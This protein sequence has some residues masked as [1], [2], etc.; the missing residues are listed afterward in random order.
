MSCRVPGADDLGSFWRLL[1]DGT[2][3]IGDVPE[4]RWDL[5]GIPDDL[6]AAGLRRG[7]FLERVADF[8]A[9]FFG[10]SPR[11][12]AAMDPRQRLALELS[13]TA[14]EHAGIVPERLRGE[15]AAVFLGA[16]G[17]DYAALTQLHGQDAVSHHSLTGLSR[18][19]IANRISYHLGLRG[20]SLTV[21]TAQSSS[22]VAVHLAGES[23]LSGATSLALAGGVHL[24]LTP[25]GTLAFAR[26]GALSPDGRCHVF[27]ARAAGT[28]RGEGAG[29]VVL[30]RL[31]DALA[32]GDRIHCVLLG[33]AVNND[34]GGATFT[35]PDG[36]AQR[37]LLR[38]ACDRAGVEP[39]DVRYV[40]LHGTGTRAGDPVEAAALGAVL[41][42]GRPRERPLLVGSVKT[43]IGHLDGASGVIG[44]IKAAL[45]IG[46]RTLPASLHYAEPN[47]AI[48]LERLRIRVNDTAGPWPEGRRLAGVSSF[49]L[50]G[51]N[52]HLVVAE[53]HGEPGKDT[54]ADTDGGDRAPARP[55]PVL[56][57][58][59]TEAALCAQAR[60]LL[61]WV[62]SDP[63]LRPADV[64]YATVT[65]RSVLEH[66]GVVVAEDR[67]ELLAG[68]AALA[69]GEPSPQLARGVAADAPGMVW[70][71][72]GQGPQWAGMALDLWETSAVF[73]A[74]MDECARLLD[75]L[76]DW[77]LR[78]VLA[79]EDALR[80]M[81][82]MQPALFAVQVSLA[83]VWRA[84]GPAPTAVVGHSQG[85]IT[86][87]CTAGIVS[88]DDALRLM[89]ERSRVITA[90]LSG[91]GAMAMLAMPVEQVDRSRVTVGAVN[92]P[93]AV[94]VSGPVDAVRET[95][96]ECEARGV[97]TR[98]VPIDYA[99]HSP[100]VEEIRYEVLRAAR[101]VTA[102]PADVAFYSTVTGARLDADALDA[103]YWYRNLREPVRLQA[104]VQAL[105]ED[106]HRVFVE[107]SPHPVLTTP[108]QDTLDGTGAIVQG[109][110]RR[111]DGSLRRLLLS[112]AELHVRGVALDWRPVFEGTGARTVE[113]PTYAFRRTPHWISGDPARRPTANPASAALTEPDRPAA[114]TQA[115]PVDPLALVRSQAAAVLGHADPGAVESG[116]T[117]KALGFDSVTSVELSSR[118]SS[119]TGLRL[120]SSLLYDHP[121]PAVLAAHLR[122][123]L[124]GPAAGFAPTTP[125]AQDADDRIAIVG[126]GCR[127]PGGVASPDDLWRLVRDGTDAIS[128]FPQDRGWSTDP[129][130]AGQVRS[131]GFLTGALDFD[132]DFFRIS[133]REARAMD[134]QQRLLLEVSWEALE[135][136]AIDPLSLRGSRTAV[137]TGVM[138]QDY[139]PRL[140]ETTDSFEGHALT[141]GATS[142]ASG[143][144]AYTLG[145]EGPA[146]TVDTACSSSLVSLHLAAQSLRAGDC[147]LA[148]AGGATVMSTP[149]M[150]VEF[151]RQGGLSPDGRCRAFADGAA[152]TGWAE[153][154]GVLVLERLADA[155][156]LGHRVLAVVRGSAVNQDGAS[157]GLTAPHGP[158]QERVIRAALAGA[159]L[160]PADV[161]AVEAHGTGT[162]LG[163]PI[164][165]Q[166]L[167]ATY[168]QGRPA[169]R[170]LWLGSLKSNIGHAQAA[171]GVGGVIKTVMALRLGVLPRTLHAGAPSRHVDWSSGA[172]ELL[173][174]ERDWP[175]PQRPRRAAVSSF[176]ISGTNAHVILEEAAQEG[177]EA[178]A[179]DVRGPLPV[180]L[181]GAG[182][183]ALRAQALRLRQ[184]VESDAELNVRDVGF[185]AV[186]TRPALR[187][188]AVVVA[189]D[190]AALLDR[191]DALARGTEDPGVSLGT[192]RTAG[193]RVVFVFP[194]QGSQW[195]GMAVE[196]L[197]AS[198]V[199]ERR[200]REC[201]AALAEFVDWDLDGVL[202]GAPGAPTLER[203][204]VVQPASWAV[205]VSLA[206]LWQSYGVEPAAVVGHS[207]GEIA[208]AC[209]AG[210]LEL[211]DGARVVAL[212]SQAIARGLAGHG[213]MMSVALPAVETESRLGPWQ[214][215][216][217]VA[218]LNGPSATVVAGD[219]QALEDLLAE[220]RTDGVR[221]RIIPVDYA[222]HTS[223][224]ERIEDE[225]AHVLA[226][227]RPRPA[228][229]PFFSTVEQDWL[230]EQAVDAGYWYRN[231]RHQ[232]HFD[233]AVRALAGQGYGPFVEVSSHPVLS[234]SIV[235]IL[236]HRTPGQDP[237]VCGTLRRDEGGPE[238]FLASAARL[239]THGVPVDWSRGAYTGTGAARVALPTYA[240]QRRRHWA[241]PLADRPLLTDAVELADGGDLLLTERLSLR[242]RPWLT[243]HRVLGRCVVPGTALLE[244]ALR[245]GD[246]VDEL[247]L[248]TPLV[249][250]DE[251][252]VEVQL[253]A[254]APD[255]S[256]RRAFR[257][258]GRAHDGTGREWHLHATGR[259][260]RAEPGG[261]RETATQWPPPGAVPVDRTGWY[262]ELAG[263]GLEYG[264]AFRNLRRVWRDGEDLLAEV[265]LEEAAGPFQVHPALLD[266]VLHPLVLDEGPGPVVPFSWTG[267]RAA[268][269]G[270]TR[271]RARVS[272]LGDQRAALTVADGSG[273]EVL[274]VESLALRPLD[275]RRTHP[276][277]FQVDWREITA[278]GSAAPA[279]G[280]TTVLP[281]EPSG[282]VAP[283]TV[284]AVAERVL[285]EV[286]AWL[287]AHG[288]GPGRL[289]VVTRRAVAAVAGDAVELPAATVW[290]LLRS[291]QSEHPGRV[292]LVDR[293]E[294]AEGHADDGLDRALATAETQLA[295][296]S[297]RILVP[298]LSRGSVP[299]AEPGAPVFDP[300]GT[301][302]ITGGT[303]GL[304]AMVARHLVHRHGV[305]QL[306]LVSR[307]GTAAD[308]AAELTA[309]LTGA[310]AD[311][312]VV[313]C[314]VTD[315]D[316]LGDV[317]ASVPGTAPLRAVVHAAGV[318]QDAAATSLS[319]EQLHTVLS[320]KADSAWHLHELTRDL[321]L[322]AFVLFSSVSATIGLPG[323]ANYAAANAFLDAL[324]HRRTA[325]GLPAVSLGWGLW[326]R[327]TG[328]TGR[329]SDTDRQRILRRGLRPLATDEGLALFDL[330]VTAD[331][332]HLVPA[333]FDLS[334]PQTEVPAVLRRPARTPAPSDEPAAQAGPSLRE[335]LPALAE[336]DRE[337]TVRRLVQQEI[338]TVLGRSGPDDVPA[339]RGFMELGFDSLTALE[340]RS[341]LAAR[342]ALTLNAT[343]TFDHPSATALTRHLLE[344]LVP[345]SGPPAP[346]VPPVLADLDRL[347]A[348][349]T[350]VDDDHLH[351]DVTARL[352]DLL[353]TLT[354]GDD[355]TGSAH[356]DEIAA[357]TADELF[358]LIDDELGRPSA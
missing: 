318:L 133:P 135:H 110:L 285:G 342:T 341:R 214:G 335:R 120:P 49:G 111:G 207:Q 18:G 216:L 358:A 40:E 136:A 26:A 296:R 356:D 201:A 226:E 41:G 84:V 13:W 192:G 15:N 241:H 150:F 161:D 158:S 197:D 279:P 298:R 5:A 303:G 157:N 177:P 68:L 327:G 22:L 179:S 333:R 232:V 19:A 131:G 79:D 62:E 92:G 275:A 10:I 222:S 293:Q 172:V 107:A 112:L 355:V 144:V 23:L 245:I 90:R 8:D 83:E 31:T 139:V 146:V 154:A 148:L 100:Q 105:A 138:D 304:G 182:E 36:D 301:V 195:T 29:V 104:A 127:F 188:R 346:Q 309:E 217:E 117:F 73:A 46:H 149:G 106:G 307:S 353:S 3:A 93:D 54:G 233:T 39:A 199:F 242:T 60:R 163:D 357:A 326:E 173:V 209:V 180:V 322:T 246:V 313:A 51:T 194:G 113:L 24:N 325:D 55:V 141:G 213:G 170:P 82:V 66:R 305:R 212:R 193:D 75:G 269:N 175:R 35:V 114:G 223:L 324:A 350:S 248:H 50:G 27:D 204:D 270:A 257:V 61:E 337:L 33:S 58:G 145:L 247:V 64:G 118:L 284:H 52:C 87:A 251:G 7:G 261:S 311:V 53:G 203:V 354:V 336:A 153:G 218:A 56:V 225:L 121:T 183:A 91:R 300:A 86:A 267:V 119:E 94:V 147:T 67:A 351:A 78:E 210:A 228:H 254:G 202:R 237:L 159:G 48:P 262:E 265:A 295:V 287:A 115:R 206:A 126:M 37:E 88:L 95:V 30:K 124:S 25:A 109:T 32:D 14:L 132:A 224:V 286:Q 4:G 283:D 164:E 1:R 227:V 244:M 211:R 280:P 289:A 96:R 249:V 344:R 198:P 243:D 12:A 349:V 234:T 47:P 334:G 125:A 352:L 332:P 253:T 264:P 315:R 171:A 299:A 168:G 85:E 151:S 80:R 292:V 190:R 196:L 101:R 266:A 59:R 263:R 345:P 255:A 205:M 338:A 77:S 134:P 44:L 65:T 271:L 11:E 291:V 278:P 256:G 277:L 239:W 250:P 130:Q 191:L 129:A 240:F 74:R 108:I 252:D 140:H 156:R 221:A 34:G 231:L 63:A 155:R 343:V 215:R 274:S 28:A 89:V 340:L 330:A 238:R 282:P 348:S 329:L 312:R 99:S 98:M 45:A 235:E 162:R 319:P 38:A 142:V 16:T 297:G 189:E 9:A 200:M 347:S 72:P 236:E 2:D 281:V 229:V 103:E 230:G 178:G 21:D 268:G 220:C 187:H 17:D 174:E 184:R 219:P 181:S 167:L 165:A 166:A 331:R 328:L 71:F 302:L 320:A 273:T 316:A 6:L 339:E 123:R 102:R 276:R 288:D 57:S 321:D 70:V 323:Q 272:R 160:A 152:G 43:N 186:E 76:V 308:G 294:P 185:S 314:D 258:H 259:A 317:V 260:G 169:E 97:R 81:D 42:R 20:P 122:D 128:G 137:F 306:L 290:G 69:A 310:G 143:R 208:A 176:G 116:H